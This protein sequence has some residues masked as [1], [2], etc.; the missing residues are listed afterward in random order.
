M[1]STD[2]SAR[3][4]NDIARLYLDN[5]RLLGQI[6]RVIAASDAEDRAGLRAA[7][8]EL[9]SETM[10][11]FEQ[12]ERL[13]SECQYEAAEAHQNEHQQLLIEIRH[14]IADLNAGKISV[15]HIGR[16]MHNWIL[17]HIV[18]KDSQFVS[19]MLT[20]SGITDRRREALASADNNET[21]P[22]LPDAAR[23]DVAK[24]EERRLENL[25][26]IDWSS[27]MEI[28]VPAIDDDHRAIITLLG[29]IIE[30][31]KATDKARLAELLEHL[32]NA[33][34]EHFRVEEELMSQLDKALF[35]AHKAEHS[36]L[37]D[38][39]ANQVDEFRKNNTSAE[40]LCR[41]IHRWFVRHIENL[42]TALRPYERAEKTG[43]R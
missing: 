22:D 10:A 29:A 28:G 23:S 16:F 14:Q 7:L 36:S 15:A 34:A 39:Y 6:K 41:F 18:S 19:A 32:G 30:A 1:Y 11:R 13:M 42:D 40:F 35:E 33:T 20:Q 21:A 38:E 4:G 43:D 9:L 12:E 2:L 27:S 25:A 37:L 24:F 5:Q 31:N 3:L 26:P 17:Q 8:L